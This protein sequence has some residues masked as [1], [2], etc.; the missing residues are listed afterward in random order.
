MDNVKMKN[1]KKRLLKEYKT[2]S[3]DE[4]FNK[5]AFANN[6]IDNVPKEF[7]SKI[8]NEVY[9]ALAL[10]IS[11]NI[12]M[13]KKISDLLSDILSKGLYSDVIK[14]PNEF[15]VFRGMNVNREWLSNVLKTKEFEIPGKGN[16]ELNFTFVPLDNRG[17]TSWSNFETAQ[18]FAFGFQEGGERRVIKDFDIILIAK[19]HENKNKFLS[20]VDGLYKVKPMSKYSSENEYIGLGEIAVS[21]LYWYTSKGN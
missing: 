1:F 19:V 17:S 6:R 10:H 13:S 7:D 16:K 20:C 21:G 12:Q 3:E 11:E 2:E 18:E 4:I 5:Y 9:K 14:E 15:E 8:E